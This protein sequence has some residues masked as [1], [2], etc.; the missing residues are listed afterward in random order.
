MTKPY[1][2]KGDWSYFV[3]QAHRH[4]KLWIA[5]DTRGYIVS[6]EILTLLDKKIAEFEQ[7]GAGA[8]RTGALK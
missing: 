6:A 8:S 5:V 4:T 3:L 2:R 1:A 7:S